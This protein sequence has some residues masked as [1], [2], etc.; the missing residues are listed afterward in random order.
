MYNGANYL[1]FQRQSYFSNTIQ[2]MIE[3]ALLKWTSQMIE[4]NGSGRT[5]GKVHAL[6]QVISFNIDCDINERG[7]RLAINNH[8]PKDIRIMSVEF[9]D[10]T[11]HARYHSKQKRYRYLIN[12]QAYDLFQ[13]DRVYQ[14]CREVDITKLKEAAQLFI[15]RHDFYAFCKNGLEDNTIREILDINI[16]QEGGTIQIEMTGKG[17]LRHMVRV[18]VETLL[19][20]TRN[21]ITLETISKLLMDANTKVGYCA[22]PEGL[23]LVEVLYD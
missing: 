16:T 2:G 20:Y 7:V 3:A 18:I 1:G 8:L 5:D 4:I 14:Y 15:G 11:F 22:A 21:K 13:Y 6:G 12:T 23:Y 17:F 10:E 19:V 9:V